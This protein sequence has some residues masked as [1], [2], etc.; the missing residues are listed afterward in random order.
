MNELMTLSEDEIIHLIEVMIN[1]G[2][3]DSYALEEVE[4]LWL[5]NI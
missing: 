1:D 5:K 3:G 4:K 2:I